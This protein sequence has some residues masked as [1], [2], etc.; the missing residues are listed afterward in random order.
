MSRSR[1]G[2][3]WAL[4]FVVLPAALVGL[5]ADGSAPSGR[6]GPIVL[7]GSLRAAEAERFS[8]P[9]ASNWQQTLQWLLPEGEA[10]QAGDS[11]ALF[12]PAG[13]RP[14]RS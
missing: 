1:R 10:V 6:P 9:V 12:D 14:R 2:A 3:R 8:V 7:T 4:S 13:S 5:A 11:I